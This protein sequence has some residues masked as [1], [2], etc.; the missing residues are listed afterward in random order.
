MSENDKS[1]TIVQYDSFKEA[2]ATLKAENP[3]SSYSSYY[4]DNDWDREEFEDDLMRL[5][6][7]KEFV[8]TFIDEFDKNDVLTKFY[9]FEKNN[10]FWAF[11]Q[12]YTNVVNYNNGKPIIFFSQ[13][14]A[15]ENNNL[16][17]FYFKTEQEITKFIEFSKDKM[18]QIEIYGLPD[19][20]KQ[21]YEQDEKQ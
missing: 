14:N 11:A 8:D 2:A 9:Y 1:K 17:N 6:A 15:V 18:T 12:A 4:D 19:I 5:N 21:Y 7:T 3:E 20:I 13:E 16:N 10:D